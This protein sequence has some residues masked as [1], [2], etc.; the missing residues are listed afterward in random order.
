MMH[1]SAETIKR[2]DR[3]LCGKSLKRSGHVST[4]RGPITFS[5]PN[6][7]LSKKIGSRKTGHPQ[8]DPGPDFPPGMGMAETVWPAK[9]MPYSAM[10]PAPDTSPACAGRLASRAGR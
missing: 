8:N 7:K 6:A 10:P 3:D 5:G 4:Q 1:E 2:L 9:E